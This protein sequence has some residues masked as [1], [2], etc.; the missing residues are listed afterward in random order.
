M[1]QIQELENKI[2]NLSDIYENQDWLFKIQYDI[3][4]K[5]LRTSY[6]SF[7]IHFVYI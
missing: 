6:W 7:K 1:E 4:N 2:K 5:L 3:F